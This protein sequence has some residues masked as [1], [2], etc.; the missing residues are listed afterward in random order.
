MTDKE[1]ILQAIQAQRWFFFEN[2]D[3]ILFDRDTALIWANLEHFPCAKNN[4]KSYSNAE[5]KN[6]IQKLNVQSFGGFNTWRIPTAHEFWKTIQDK[7]FPFQFGQ[8]RRIEDHFYWYVCNH[9]KF[10]IKDLDFN[11]EYKSKNYKEFNVH[12][13]PCCD[14]FVTSN[15]SSDTQEILYIF[16]ANDLIPIF[17]D[18]SID[19]LY[20]KYF[21]DKSAHVNFTLSFDYRKLSSSYNLILIEKSPIKYFEAVLR[22]TD[23][24]L[25]MLQKYEAAQA[26]IIAE[27]SKTALK[28]D[29]AE[30][31]R[32]ILS[33][34]AQ[35]ER[36]FERLDKILGGDNSICELAAL[37]AEPRADFEFLTE[38]L[39]RIMLA[40]QRQVEFFAENKKSL[41]A[42][43]SVVSGSKSI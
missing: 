21:S 20:K 38:N 26:E 11:C 16:T 18:V 5:I 39:V 30:T 42:N 19:N 43:Q 17:N 28:L 22:L 29:S 41:S 6:L 24:F 40:F 36:F 14:A 31:K 10:L 25:D 32:K 4:R 34:K 1:Q 23:K 2:N 9:G 7:T 3:K 12:L 15:F 8:N 35:A 13:L 37:Q 33:V 27:S